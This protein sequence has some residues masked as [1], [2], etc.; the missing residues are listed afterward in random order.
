MLIQVEC[1]NI[2]FRGEKNEKKPRDISLKNIFEEFLWFL[3]CNRI[4]VKASENSSH[5]VDNAFLP[6][7]SVVKVVKK[8]WKNIFAFFFSFCPYKV[9]LH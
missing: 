1:K 3:V 6:K 7:K 2:L 9:T 4:E 8:R 5:R